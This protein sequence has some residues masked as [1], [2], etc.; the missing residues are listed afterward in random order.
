MRTQEIKD[1]YQT[2]LGVSINTPIQCYWMPYL[3][4][5]TKYPYLLSCPLAIVELQ[6]CISLASIRSVCSMVYWNTQSSKTKDKKSCNLLTTSKQTGAQVLHGTVPLVAQLLQVPWIY[7]MHAV[8]GIT[9]YTLS[10]PA[11]HL[12]GIWGYSI[13]QTI[14]F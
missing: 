1:P 5:V 3:Y 8:C 7:R 14:N 9:K 13:C 11:F 4:P 10:T 2:F 6:P 12:E